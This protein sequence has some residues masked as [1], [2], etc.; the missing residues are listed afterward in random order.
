MLNTHVSIQ[1]L[2]RG[3]II[4]YAIP[5]RHV[6]HVSPFGD[7]SA[8]QQGIL[9]I[10]PPDKMEDPEIRRRVEGV[11]SIFGKKSEDIRWS[12]EYVKEVAISKEELVES[13]NKAKKAHDEIVKLT[14]EGV[15]FRTGQMYG[16]A[17]MQPA[18][19]I[20]PDF[21]LGA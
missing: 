9:S 6:K 13:M 19:Y 15:D 12:I 3:S 4:T 1:F 17:M 11:M 18:S 5:V 10:M 2:E 21:T 16:E 14:K 7:S 20:Q 8:I